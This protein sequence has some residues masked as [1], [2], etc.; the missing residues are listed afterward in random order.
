MS[1]ADAMDIYYH[2]EEKESGKKVRKNHRYEGGTYV[3]HD[4][5][6]EASL[7][8]PYANQSSNSFH[9]YGRMLI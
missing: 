8:Q 1:E 7:S 9:L 5:N 4:T 2:G 3:R 6:M